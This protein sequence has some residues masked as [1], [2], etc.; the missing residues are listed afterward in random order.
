[1]PIKIND[2]T[3]IFINNNNINLKE[4]NENGLLFFIKNFFYQIITCGLKRSLYEV[5]A[6]KEK[7]L[8]NMAFS[9]Y[10]NIPLSFSEIK[11]D[12]HRNMYLSPY[13]EYKIH[14][15]EYNIYISKLNKEGDEIINSRIELANLNKREYFENFKEKFSEI[16]EHNDYKNIVDNNYIIINELKYY[17]INMLLNFKK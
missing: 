5:R 14:Q 15:C 2:A 4:N 16:K 11:K 8:F 7:E 17:N 13:R 6:E 3:N 9:V 10:K 1:M 12:Y